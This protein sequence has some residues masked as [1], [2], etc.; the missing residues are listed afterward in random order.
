M[1]SGMKGVIYNFFEIDVRSEANDGVE[2]YSEGR[3]G[4]V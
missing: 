3:K 4:A 1:S 2:T